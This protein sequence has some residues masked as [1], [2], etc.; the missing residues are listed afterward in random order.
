L[1]S[2]EEFIEDW[3]ISL[4]ATGGVLVTISL[5]ILTI[6]YTSTTIA[7]WQAVLIGA[8]VLTASGFLMVSVFYALDAHGTLILIVGATDDERR[9]QLS[10]RARVRARRAEL[11]FKASLI[12][13]LTAIVLTVILPNLPTSTSLLV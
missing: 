10:E 4:V 13:L 11:C 12:L 6:L 3:L 2:V 7:R 5:M 8:V 9:Q 1:A